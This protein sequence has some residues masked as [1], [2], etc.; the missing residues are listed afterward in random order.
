[1]KPGVGSFDHPATGFAADMTLEVMCLLTTGP[2]MEREAEFCGE[3]R[4]F[5]IIVALVE[6][7]ALGCR[8]G[9]RRPG[10]RD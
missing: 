6:A 9:W 10:D 8:G 3:G 7:Q 1:M 4:N 2:E 5:G